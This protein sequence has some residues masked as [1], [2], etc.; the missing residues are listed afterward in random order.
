MVNYRSL[1]ANRRY[2]SDLSRVTVLPVTDDDAAFR[3]YAIYKK[4]NYDRVQP[5]LD[6]YT[7]ARKILLNPGKS[8]TRV[9]SE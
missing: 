5:A 1:A 7:R 4:D 9:D 3:L 2:L 8:G 6:A